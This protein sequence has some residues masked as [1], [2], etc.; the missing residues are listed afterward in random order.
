MSAITIKQASAATPHPNPN[1]D[2]NPPKLPI[3]REYEVRGVKYIVSATTK[4]GAKEDTAAIIRRL[5]RKELGRVARVCS[6]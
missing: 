3:T 2:L 1:L 5:L 4:N 6:H